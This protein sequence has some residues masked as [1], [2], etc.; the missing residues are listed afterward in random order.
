MAETVKA[1]HVRLKRVPMTRWTATTAAVFSST[2]YG[3]AGSRK[4][5]P[6]STNG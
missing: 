4:T 1:A 2:A 6:A 3:R 5:M